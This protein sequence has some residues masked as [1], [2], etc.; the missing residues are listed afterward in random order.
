MGVQTTDE[1]TL[2]NVQREQYWRD[3]VDGYNVARSAEFGRVS[4]DLIFG[5]KTQDMRHWR[6]DVCRVADLRPDSITTYDCLYRGR[7]RQLVSE[8]VPLPSLDLLGQMYDWSYDYLTGCGYHADYGSVNF[9]RHAGELGTS[10]Y[11]EKRILWGEPYIGIGN[12]ATTLL[13]GHW[14]FNYRNVDDYANRV[15]DGLDAVEFH[16]EL[17]PEE[18]FAKYLLYSL[19]YGVIMPNRFAELFGRDLWDEYGPELEYAISE[20]WLKKNTDSNTLSVRR[21]SRI[22]LMRSLFYTSEARRWLMRWCGAEDI[23]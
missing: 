6:E 20:G 21:F 17:P 16:Y 23:G 19:N 12:Y 1:G 18:Q 3:V 8:D 13:G 11:F 14:L 15:L 9:S 22:H 10:K 5:L 4:M 2:R 7:G